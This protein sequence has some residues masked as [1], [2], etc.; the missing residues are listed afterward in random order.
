MPSTSPP[1]PSQVEAALGRG[2]PTFEDLRVLHAH[3][4]YSQVPMTWPSDARMLIRSLLEKLEGVAVT[5]PA[6]RAA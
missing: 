5:A 2:R 4:D 3:L 1:L 6:R